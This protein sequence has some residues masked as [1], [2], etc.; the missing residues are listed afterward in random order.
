MTD[1]FM[2]PSVDFAGRSSGFALATSPKGNHAS[3]DFG[4]HCDALD[5]GAPVASL[6]H[7]LSPLFISVGAHVSLDIRLRRI[8]NVGRWPG[9]RNG[10]CPGGRICTTEKAATLPSMNANTDDSASVSA[11]R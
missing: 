5:K 1:G 10:N 4:R 9:G 8:D 6:N 11:T 7:Q 2:S 3:R